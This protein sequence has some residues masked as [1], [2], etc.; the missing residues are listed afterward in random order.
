L[1][2][3]GLDLNP[4]VK[5]KPWIRDAAKATEKASWDSEEG[6]VSHPHIDRVLELNP[7]LKS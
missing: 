1:R 2:F 5:L 4:A 7:T 3:R 6:S